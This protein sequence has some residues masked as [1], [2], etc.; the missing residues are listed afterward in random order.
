MTRFT[1]ETPGDPAPASR[2]AEDSIRAGLASSQ[3]NDSLGAIRHFERAATLGPESGVP[4]F[5]LGSEYA[6]LGHVEKAELAF[7][8]AVLLA[9]ALHLARYQLGLLQF[10]LGR[11]AV[12]FVTWGPLLTLDER[13]ALPHLVR[14][15]A[16]LAQDQAETARAHFECGL[17]R[18][19]SNPALSD[20]IRKVIEEMGNPRQ[21]ADQGAPDEQSANHILISNYGKSGTLH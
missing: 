19:A 10:S 4:H 18:N 11:A 8:N 2:E 5:L 16:A 6:A 21:D 20:D 12:A 3:T 7:A 9:P 14:G 15:F 1:I 17:A 13:E